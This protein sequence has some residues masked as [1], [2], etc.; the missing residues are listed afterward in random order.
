MYS[1]TQKDYEYIYKIADDI[2]AGYK[3]RDWESIALVLNKHFKTKLTAKQWKTQHDSGNRRIS[4]YGNPAARSTYILKEDKVATKTESM[5]S[6]S[7]R[8]KKYLARPKSMEQIT[9]FLDIDK[10]TALGIIYQLKIQHYLITYDTHNETYFMEKRVHQDPKVYNHS[11]GKITE[12]EFLVISDS[13]WCQ[14]GQQKSFVE[15]IYDEAERRGIK[16]VYHV[17]DITDGY[18]K[19][20]PEQIYDLFAI[21]SDQQKDYV[22]KNWPKKKGITTYLIIGNHDETHIRNGGFNIGTAIDNERND[23]QYL[24]IGHAKIML[25]PNCRMDLLHPLDGSSYAVSYSGQKYMDALTGGDKPN[26]LFVGHHHKVLYFPYRNIHYF[27]V[28]SM[29]KQSSWMKRKRIAN[30]SGAWF[31]KLKVDEEGTIVSVIPEHIKQY[32]Y[33]END[34]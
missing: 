20:R 22:V 26:I 32:K 11:I 4:K 31:V 21:G 15:Y 33:L 5:E 10:I 13:H 2:P 28:P 18:Y 7:L 14:T 34:Y 24:G 27:E 12:V 30:A 23:I 29:T 1:K 3:T 25:T 17:G 19:N 6:K 8:L 16:S 9:K